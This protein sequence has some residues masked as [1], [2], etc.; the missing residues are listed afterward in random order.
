M[1]ITNLLRYLT[2]TSPNGEDDVSIELV[3]DSTW[4]IQNPL[5][6][7]NL[8]WIFAAS[9]E[10]SEFFYP[11]CLILDLTLY[12][13]PWVWVGK[14]HNASALQLSRRPGD[15]WWSPALYP[16][17]KLHGQPWRVPNDG[18]RVCGQYKQGERRIYLQSIVQAGLTA[19]WN[20]INIESEGKALVQEM[21]NWPDW[22]HLGNQY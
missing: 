8:H 1:G 16:S 20:G 5:W 9:E 14:G 17:L 12:L 15:R 21:R 7:S 11:T 3:Y 6:G 13:N 10:E 2:R 19:A 4:L 18:D 22:T